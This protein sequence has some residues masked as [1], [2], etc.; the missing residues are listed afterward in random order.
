MQ[1]YNT[2]G[3]KCIKF[4]YNVQYTITHTPYLPTQINFSFGKSID[5]ICRRGSIVRISTPCCIIAMIY[6]T[7]YTE[8]KANSSQY[9][10]AATINTNTTTQYIQLTKNNNININKQV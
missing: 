9:Y 3:I 7:W 6:G 1:Y 10:D 8:T 4:Y 5:C 2:V